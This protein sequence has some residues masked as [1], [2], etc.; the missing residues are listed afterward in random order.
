MREGYAGPKASVAP[1]RTPQD[2]RN[3]NPA[4]LLTSTRIKNSEYIPAWAPLDSMC[5]LRQTRVNDSQ[6]IALLENP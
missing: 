4:M 1:L 2:A 3:Q 5:A 6:G